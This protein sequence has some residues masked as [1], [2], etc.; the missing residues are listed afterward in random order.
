MLPISNPLACRC[1]SQVD[2]ALAVG[3]RESV[4]RLTELAKRPTERTAEPAG[5]GCG[6]VSACRENNRTVVEALA[7]NTRGQPEGM[8]HYKKIERH[9]P[10]NHRFALP[11]GPSP[12]HPARCRSV[13]TNR[14]IGFQEII[15]PARR[16][17]SLPPVTYANACETRHNRAPPNY[18]R[19]GKVQ[20]QTDRKSPMRYFLMY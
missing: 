13:E 10:A 6:S 5:S 1:R 8:R 9:V 7:P 14:R 17:F 19:A 20:C 11:A 16:R 12:S 15:V 18:L 4:L 2:L 3:A